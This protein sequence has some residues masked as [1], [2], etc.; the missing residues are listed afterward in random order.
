MIDLAALRKIPYKMHGTE[1]ESGMDCF[2]FMCYVRALY[3]GKKTA[4]E[5]LY[6]DVLPSHTEMLFT[7]SLSTGAFVEVTKPENGDIVMLGTKTKK[8]YHHC[9][10][11]YNGYV[12]H[13][14]GVDNRTGG[15]YTHTLHTIRRVYSKIGFYKETS[16]CH[17]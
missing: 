17:V 11:W 13:C 14:A 16:L 15:V 12:L 1:P 8:P 9:G 3:F 5:L 10:V 2:T 4:L 6:T 7:E